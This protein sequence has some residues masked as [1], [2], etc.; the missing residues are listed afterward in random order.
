MTFQGLLAFTTLSDN[1]RM[2][3][4][5]VDATSPHNPGLKHTPFLRYNRGDLCQAGSGLRDQP[6]D[7]YVVSVETSGTSVNRVRRVRGKRVGGTDVPAP[8]TDQHTDI[9]WVANL[10]EVHGKPVDLKRGCL[11]PN[12]SPFHVI[13]RVDLDRGEAASDGVFPRDHSGPPIKWYFAK[14]TADGVDINTTARYSQ[15]LAYAVAIAFDVAE[16]ESVRLVLTHF[17]DAS[18]NTTLE[19]CGAAGSIV[20][21]EVWNRSSNGLLV[22]DPLNNVFFD[23]HFHMFYDLLD[24]S[25]DTLIP[26]TRRTPTFFRDMQGRILDA[27]NQLYDQENFE[28]ELEKRALGPDSQQNC[29]PPGGGGG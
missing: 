29:V 19:F 9:T 5:L 27:D 2:H 18:R 7:N 22:K 16:G 23:P 12:P 15:A 8:G 11:G 24:G 17:T 26:Y 20:A 1:D 6:L 25:L 21:P 13:A 28:F 10:S 4:V 3:V 14:A